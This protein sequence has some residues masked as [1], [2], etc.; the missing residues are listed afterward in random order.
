MEELEELFYRVIDH[1]GGQPSEEVPTVHAAEPAKR[2]ATDFVIPVG[3][4]NHHI[5]L[6]QAD[7]D[8]LFGP[9]YQFQKLKDL[10]QT[11]Q[12]A[13]QECLFVAG[14][15]GVLEKVRILGPVRSQSQVELTVADC[16]KLGIKA[17][18]RLSGDLAGSP[19]CTLIGP[20]GSVQLTKGCIVAKRHI[21]M[22]PIDAKEFGV[23]DGQEVSLECPGERGGTLKNV[24]I[25]VHES[26]TLECHLDTEEANALGISAKNKLK[27]L[28]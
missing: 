14:P 12:Y 24:T 8:A 25:R 7:A 28:K 16:F 19:G 21:H 5:H 18:L 27:L 20:K 2:D 13:M 1:L 17:P 10:S 4:S 26:F 6:S 22:S 11:G 23:I 15:K 9:D 3:V